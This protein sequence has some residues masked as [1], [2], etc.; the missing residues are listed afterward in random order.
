MG[1]EF[2]FGTDPMA[3]PAG[4]SAKTER[5]MLHQGG[6]EVL[7]LTQG[8]FRSYLFPVFTPRGFAVTAESPA[9]HPHH[10]SIWIGSDNVRCLVPANDGEIENYTYNFYVNETFQGRAPGKI[11]TMAST[12][13]ALGPRGFRVNQTLE[14]RGPPEWG[15]PQGRVIARERRTIDFLP[16]QSHHVIEIVCELQPTQWDLEFGPTRHAFLNVRVTETMRAS[17]G[18]Q[19]LDARGCRDAKSISGSNAGWVD[20]SGPVGGGN[21]AGITVMPHPDCGPAWWFV[22]DWGV[23]TAGHFRHEKRRIVRGESAKFEFRVIVHD[24]AAV[25]TDIA[26]LYKSYANGA[27]D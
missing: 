20:L 27:R 21:Q 23:M 2:Q 26:G 17:A 19:L 10:N 18:G 16:G 22:S 11:L 14:W 7:G 8:Q 1:N 15:A 25:E 12:G 9:D 13:E 5:C 24:G 3:L 6:R 4:A